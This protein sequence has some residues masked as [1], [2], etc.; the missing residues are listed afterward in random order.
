MEIVGWGSEEEQHVIGSDCTGPLIWLMLDE[1]EAGVKGAC[2]ASGGSSHLSIV[3]NMEMP[4][5]QEEEF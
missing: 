2:W 3:R 4:I 5:H 1:G